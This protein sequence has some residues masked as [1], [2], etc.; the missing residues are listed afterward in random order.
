MHRHKNNDKELGKRLLLLRK[1]RGWS[2]VQL[3]QR[4]GISFQQIQKYERGTNKLSFDRICQLSSI[5]EVNVGYWAGPLEEELAQNAAD[6]FYDRAT[7]H[8]IQSFH[9]IKKPK[10]RE[11]LSSLARELASC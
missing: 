9:R 2:Q 10:L 6:L 11:L 4:L 7:L 5:F 1:A 8:L 3:G